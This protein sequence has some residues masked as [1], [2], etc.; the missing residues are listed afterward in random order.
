M[1]GQGRLQGP[2]DDRIAAG[3]IEGRFRLAA[4]GLVQTPERPM[5]LQPDRVSAG[6]FAN[7]RL[8]SSELGVEVLLVQIALVAGVGRV[9]KD[10]RKPPRSTR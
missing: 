6:G 9:K 7:E 1:R 8:D 3:G 5:A 4:A 2:I 10:Q